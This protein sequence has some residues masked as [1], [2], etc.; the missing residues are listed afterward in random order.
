MK[1][2]RSTVSVVS[3]ILVSAGL[4][5]APATGADL[6]T[7]S[8]LFAIN[9]QRGAV[10]GIGQDAGKDRIT[11]RLRG[12]S[13]HATQFSDRP[14]REAYVLSTRDFVDRWSRWF[15]GDPPNA[16]LTFNT[17]KDPMP[18][19]IVL[20]LKRPRYREQQHTLTFTAWHLHRKQ[21]PSP[22]AEETVRLPRT[23]A[24]SRFIRA[25][26]F[27]DSVD[28]PPVING[29]RLAQG[30]QCPNV[31]LRYKDLTRI[32]LA[33]ADLSGANLFRTDL[34]GANLS[35]ANLSGARLSSAS[36]I[37]ANLSGADLSGTRMVF[38]ML[39]GADLTGA[40]LRDA[41]MAYP[42]FHDANLSGAIWTDGRRCAVDLSRS[43]ECL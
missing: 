25:S 16:V 32:N 6:D 17:R 7:P 35:A 36:L 1:V 30:A 23:K 3:T 33:G 34:T 40:N 18:H 27:I 2:S 41:V 11:V 13:D 5:V 22:D 43:G 29:C 42:D 10:L 15:E 19:S 20:E 39:G 28:E 38:T 8:Y 26:L 9:A 37:G 14:L 21:D 12:V 24:P 31:D 4:A